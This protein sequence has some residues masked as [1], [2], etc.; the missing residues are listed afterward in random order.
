LTKCFIS[1]IETQ[2][3]AYNPYIGNSW[4]FVGV[5]IK[6]GIFTFPTDQI[7]ASK[8]GQDQIRVFVSDGLN[9]GFDDAIRLTAN[10]AQY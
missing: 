9:T 2:Q 10:A 1:K 7:Q 8:E 6:G 5:R 3:L 4:F